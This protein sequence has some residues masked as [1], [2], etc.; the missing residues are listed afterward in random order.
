MSRADICRR[1]R[2]IKNANL[3]A[4]IL[5]ALAVSGCASNSGIPADQLSVDEIESGVA[6]DEVEI[7]IEPLTAEQD[8]QLSRARGAWAEGDLESARQILDS[9]L[10][11]RPDHPDVMTNAAI[12]ARE[13]GRREASRTLLEEALKVAPGHRVASNNLGLMLAETGEFADA[14]KVLVRAVQ[15]Y[16]EEPSLHYNLAVIYELY[17]QDLAKALEHYKQYQSLLDEPD[18]QV[19]GWIVDLERRVE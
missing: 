19:E 6:A 16:P 3:L 14:R 11:I 2:A 5:L 18:A 13:Q 7:W 15:R 1:G 10:A 8:Q 9:L 17:V 12:V 4:L